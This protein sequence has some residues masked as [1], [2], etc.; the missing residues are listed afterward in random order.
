[1]VRWNSRVSGYNNGMVSLR[2]RRVVGIIILLIS[3]A[4]LLWGFWPLG[5]AARS[6]PVLPT[7]MQLPEPAGWWVES[8]TL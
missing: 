7:H 5:D 8:L 4:L 3:L 2:I 6:V 1:M